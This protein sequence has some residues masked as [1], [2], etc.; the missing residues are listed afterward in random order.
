MSASSLHV[1]QWN[2]LCRYQVITK[3][4]RRSCRDKGSYCSANTWVMC[5]EGAEQRGTKKILAGAHLSATCCRLSHLPPLFRWKL[6][7]ASKLHGRQTVA[8][9]EHRVQREIGCVVCVR[10]CVGLSLGAHLIISNHQWDISDGLLF[11]EIMKVSFSSFLSCFA[12]LTGFYL[13]RAEHEWS[14]VLIWILRSCGFKVIWG[15]K[16]N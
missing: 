6:N 1:L 5:N 8:G 3:T 16:V 15:F 10:V 4:V 7:P 2:F 14:D 11:W 12:L 9:R 13:R